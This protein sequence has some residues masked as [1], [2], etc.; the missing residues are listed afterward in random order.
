MALVGAPWC[1]FAYAQNV[2]MV[3]GL[4]AAP[5]AAADLDAEGRGA[6]STSLLPLLLLATPR[7]HLAAVLVG[8]ILVA[9]A[10]RWALEPAYVLLPAAGTFCWLARWWRIWG[11]IRWPIGPASLAW[12]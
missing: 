2:L 12:P 8:L 6:V 5:V 1:H 3:D 4:A 11:A 7:R 9:P 10:L